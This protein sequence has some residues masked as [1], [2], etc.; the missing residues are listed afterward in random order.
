MKNPFRRH[1]HCAPAG[2]DQIARFLHD[3]KSAAPQSYDRLTS[4]AWAAAHD[5]QCAQIQTQIRS[6]AFLNEWTAE[7]ERLTMPGETVLE[8]GC[9][10]GAT[11]LYLARRGRHVTGLDYAQ[12]MC[13]T[14]VANA[15]ALGLNV[16]S[17]CADITRPL[18]ITDNTFDVVWHAG[19]IEHFSPAESQF[20]IRENARVARRCVI[21][22]APNAASIA[23]RI[24][25]EYA[26][27]TG[28][29]RAGTEYPKYT[30]QDLFI[31]AGLGDI[32]EYSIDMDFALAFLPPGQL[33]D[34][35]A[36][37]YH[38]L[39]TDDDIHQGYLLVTIGYKK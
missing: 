21:S 32:R 23:Y 27:R 38:N 39:P 35:L 14:F 30:Q 36:T 16:S 19:V 7:M 13:D 15:A 34:T 10:L 6:D 12:R 24:G 1:K 37:I 2:T 25:K 9:A 28:A 11:S 22:M 17:I 26:E 29:W 33:R 31:N 3:I 4:D 20:I 18:P 8:I 5:D